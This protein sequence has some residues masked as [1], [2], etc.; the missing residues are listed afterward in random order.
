MS[1]APN[2]P[3]FER[4]DT[5]AHSSACCFAYGL[6]LPSTPSDVKH[7]YIYIYIYIYI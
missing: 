1:A 7:S 4:T 5:L 6:G 2:L 3:T